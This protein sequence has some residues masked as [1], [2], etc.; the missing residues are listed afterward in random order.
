[1]RARARHDRRERGR[2]GAKLETALTGVRAA[3]IQLVR[4]KPVD[5][6]EHAD[7]FSE[8]FNHASDDVHDHTR[9]AQF[10]GQPGQL[11]AA[12]E[13]G[14]RVGETDG[15]DH[16]VSEVCHTRRGRAGPRLHADRLRDEPAKRIEANDVSDFAAVGRCPRGEHDRI[17]ERHARGRDRE[18]LLIRLMHCIHLP[19]PVGPPPTRRS[20]WAR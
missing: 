20:Y 7:H 2:I 12:N 19:R 15:V 10:T 16:A 5:R 13:F 3:D 8:I 18:R 17:L 14:A 11:L 9:G 6:I 4:L 1:M